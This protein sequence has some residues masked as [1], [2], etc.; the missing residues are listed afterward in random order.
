LRGRTAS[1]EFTKKGYLA[2]DTRILP[3]HTK[4]YIDAGKY[5][6]IY[7]VKD[8]GGKIK[9]RRIDIWLN[10]KKE[11]IQFGKRKVKLTILKYGYNKTRSL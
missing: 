1:G 7:M 5:S 6:G 3:M 8:R 9:G 4:V 10:S 11:A 2:A